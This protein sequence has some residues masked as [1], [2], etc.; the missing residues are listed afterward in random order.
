MYRH[1]RKTNN[2]F[3]IIKYCKGIMIFQHIYIRLERKKNNNTLNIIPNYVHRQINIKF[4]ITQINNSYIHLK[5]SSTN[6]TTELFTLNVGTI[7]GKFGTKMLALFNVSPG[8]DI[9]GRVESHHI[10]PT[11]EI[12]AQE[13][14]L[15][16]SG[17]G[18][19]GGRFTIHFPHH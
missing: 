8:L 1:H 15:Q 16:R 4:C 3:I 14:Y 5:F 17:W 9:A 12:F 7:T 18:R 6:I 13:T 10:R 2:P 19:T 11:F